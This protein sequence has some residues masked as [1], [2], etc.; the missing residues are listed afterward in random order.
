MIVSPGI[1]LFYPELSALVLPSV[2]KALRVP[3]LPILLTGDRFAHPSQATQHRCR[4]DL[5]HC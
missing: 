1:A 3:S 4:E 5:S 2:W